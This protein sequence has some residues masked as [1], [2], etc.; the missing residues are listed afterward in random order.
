[1]RVR[2]PNLKPMV[3]EVLTGEEMQA[4]EDA[5]R[6]ERDKLLDDQAGYAHVDSSDDYAAAMAVLLGDQER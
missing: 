1:V 6:T 5:A 4:M 2:V 3:I